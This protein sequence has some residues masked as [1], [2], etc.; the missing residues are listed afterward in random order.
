MLGIGAVGDER[1]GDRSERG[2]IRL[3]WLGRHARQVWVR[4]VGARRGWSFLADLAALQVVPPA[5]RVDRGG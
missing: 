4:L 5:Y 3:R 2:T 1:A